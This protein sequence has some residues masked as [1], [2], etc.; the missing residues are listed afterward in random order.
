[1]PV[2]PQGAS[3]NPPVQAHEQLLLEAY[4]IEKRKQ[5]EVDRLAEYRKQIDGAQRNSL[6]HIAD[7]VPPGM[8]VDE[9][10]ENVD[11]PV[12]T[13]NVVVPPRASARKTKQQRARILKQK[14]EVSHPMQTCR[15]ELLMTF[16]ERNKHW[17]RGLYEN[18]SCIR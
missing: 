10:V 13:G 16:I 6:G 7:G 5:D 9:I 2:P 1:M 4:Q 3:Y 18:R 15:S 11:E 17:L 8:T 12:P 14:V